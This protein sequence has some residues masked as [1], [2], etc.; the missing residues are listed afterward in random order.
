M[1]ATMVN[2]ISQARSVLT[3]ITLPAAC[4]IWANAGA[5]S[6][7]MPHFTGKE[8]VDIHCVRCHLA[9]NPTDLAKEEWPR[10]L[11]AM[12]LYM[13]MKGDELPDFV[14]V[15]PKESQSPQQTSRTLHD[16][17]GN[18]DSVNAFKAFVI[19][20]PLIGEADWLAIRNHFVE[21]A[22]PMADMFLPPPE[23]PLL[24]GF[25]P[26][27][28][29]LDIEPNGLVF[30]TLVD[31]ARQR[32]YVGRAVWSMPGVEPEEQEPDDLLAFD[33]K[34]GRRVGYTELPTEPTD[35]ELTSTGFRL[36]VHGENPMQIGN[37]QATITDWTG[38]DTRESRTRML[39]NGLHRI[40]QHQ[41][42]DLNG[43]G[44]DDI[45]ATMF[46]NGN[47]ATG[48]G[49]F[50]IFWQTPE[51][52]ELWE[53]APV[54]I[55]RGPLDGALRETVLMDRAGIMHTGIADFNHD[56]R[57]DIALLTAQGLQEIIL[58]INHGNG[59][60][61]QQVVKQHAPGFGGNSLYVEDMDG[62]GHTDIIVVNGDFSTRAPVDGYTP[63]KQYHGLRIF[64]ND[65]DLTFTQRYFYPM[66]GA[67]K[68][69]ITDYDGDGDQ[70]I[71][72][73]AQYTRWEWDEPETFV[74]LENQGG[75]EF[76]PSSLASEY[77]GVWTSVEAAD[78]NADEKPDIILGLANWPRFTPP[79]WTTREIMEGRNGEA[80]TITFLL[81]DH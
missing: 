41:T 24:E 9:P 74:Y 75:L 49:R 34:T 18:E 39:V 30:T 20:E 28:P 55:P 13:G 40:T 11:A 58:F 29:T 60:F 22:T 35:L 27:M 66:H 23:H 46:G 79:D 62:D 17:E 77:F 43:D 64:R 72:L 14:S 44:L 52:A 38:F 31:E 80:A 10:L 69:A 71:A 25:I 19:S 3:M 7:E 36:S 8:L 15:E 42:H 12:G 78:V 73:I 47:L 57:P 81:N 54:E 26:T 6:G 53:D 1:I 76:E 70:D 33:L 67:L 50:S 61:T 5:Q 2:K 56:G 16:A 37:G 68:S 63:P 45:V 48:G 32:L 4:A 65:G 51:F 59:L 21:N